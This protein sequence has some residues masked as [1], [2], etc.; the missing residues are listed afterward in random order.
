MRTDFR[1]RPRVQDM[2]N[3]MFQ[4]I[5]VYDDGGQGGAIFGE[6]VPTSGE[7]HTLASSACEA[8][9]PSG[10]WADGWRRKVVH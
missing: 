8:A 6:S 1:L 7:A 10:E 9:M 3:G 4:P 2:R 5:V